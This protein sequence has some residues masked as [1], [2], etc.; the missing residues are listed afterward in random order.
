MTRST[1]SRRAR[2]SLSV[3]TGRRRPASRPSRRRCFLASRRVE[4]FTRCGSVI[5]S[6]CGRGWRTRTTVLGASSPS[7]G[8]SPERRRERRR[9]VGALLGVAA[10]RDGR[11]RGQVR[12]LE[13]QGRSRARHEG[14]RGRRLGRG[15]FGFGILGRGVLG[16]G[17]LGD[18]LPGS[19]PLARGPSARSRARR[20]RRPRRRTRRGRRPKRLP[21]SIRVRVRVHPPCVR[22]AATASSV[23][24]PSSRPGNSRH[25]LRCHSPS[26]VYSYPGRDRAP[27]GYSLVR[28]LA[29]AEPL[30]ILQV[31]YRARCSRY[32]SCAVTALVVTIARNWLSAPC[33][34]AAFP[35]RC[36]A[37]AAAR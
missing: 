20:R 3:T 33:S 11:Q 16:S 2:N 28:R 24:R 19:R 7:R 37:L 21:P 5:G 22:R 32:V 1:L 15:V 27:A 26:L 36:A 30:P 29:W 4:P 6:G 13:Q 35:A 14:L 8:S 9:T 34:R 18:G 17:R 23:P 10:G 31:S 25:V 12:G